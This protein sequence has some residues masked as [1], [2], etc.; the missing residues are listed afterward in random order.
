MATLYNGSKLSDELLIEKQLGTTLT[1]DTDRKYVD[2]D[3]Q[4][5]I[6]VQSATE[7]GNTASADADVEFDTHLLEEASFVR[8]KMLQLS[9][10]FPKSLLAK[11]RIL[12]DAKIFVIGRNLL[13]FTGYKGFDP[14]VNSNITLGNYP[15]T[16]QY[17]I[18]AQL[19][20]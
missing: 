8:L 18:G 11:T 7:A 10:T 6:N 2:K 5:T 15:N 16:R 19:T 3:I 14:E 17:S 13:T 12:K 1:L 9:Y 20:F 4:F